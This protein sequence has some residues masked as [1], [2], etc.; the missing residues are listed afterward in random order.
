MHV[1]P[2]HGLT[3]FFD[4]DSKQIWHE[5]LGH[6]GIKVESMLSEDKVQLWYE[7]FSQ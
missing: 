7:F 6:I 5:R 3:T 1:I 2:R 4:K